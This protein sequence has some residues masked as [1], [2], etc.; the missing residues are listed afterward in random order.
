MRPLVL[1]GALL[2]ASVPA[3]AA[4]QLPL[5][6][7]VL[8]VQQSLEYQA[9]AQTI[10]RA[11]TAQL[12]AA[13]AAPGS[14]ALEVGEG[15]T[16]RRP[17]VVLDLDETALDNSA[18]SG[19]L[20]RQGVAY[21]EASWQR[22][23]ALEQAGAVPGAVEFTQ[24]AARMGLAVFYVSNRECVPLDAD[25]CPAK[26]HTMANLARLGFP[27]ASDPDALM[28]LQ[29]RAGWGSD[30]SSR[31]QSIADR[32]RIVMLLGDDLR[33]FLP[34]AA[35][36]ALRTGNAEP[37]LQGRRALFGRRWFML[38]NPMYGSWENTLPS[39]VADRLNALKLPR[40]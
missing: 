24:R 40:P 36:E 22:W 28:L 17:A 5:L 11:A 38:P 34:I 6:Q 26:R 4:D 9:S 27:R 10:Y 15:R 32:Y 1:L 33:D 12:K 16:K 8:W 2:L 30:K 3:L 18:Y 31:R 35:V 37:G 39:P 20:V 21:D 23:L 29:E 14:A 13:V 7:S 19:W 25:P